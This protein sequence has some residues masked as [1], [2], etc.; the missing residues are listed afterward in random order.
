MSEISFLEIKAARPNVVAHVCT[1]SRLVDILAK[2]GIL[3]G[4]TWSMNSHVVS[5]LSKLSVQIWSAKFAAGFCSA[6]G[7]IY[8]KH[9]FTRFFFVFFFFCKR[10]QKQSFNPRDQ[11]FNLAKQTIEETL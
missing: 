4:T 8:Q 7:G 3:F 5:S 2:N 6:G 9:T 11:D 10:E 1:I